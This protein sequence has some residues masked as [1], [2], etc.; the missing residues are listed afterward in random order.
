MEVSDMGQTALQ[1]SLHSSAAIASN[2]P[3]VFSDIK[4]MVGNVSYNT[5]TGE[6]TLSAVGR[7]V[8][9]W[10][11]AVQSSPST[12]GAAFALES[13]QGD[14]IEGNSPIKTDEVYGI[15]IIDVETAPVTMVLKNISTGPI[16]LSPVV[17]LQGTLVLLEDTLEG[18]PG[19]TG[20]TGPTGPAGEPGPIA[21][22]IPF[23]IGGYG[24][25]FSTHEDGYP[26][27]IKFSGF[28]KQDYGLL[29][30]VGEWQTGLITFDENM[31]YGTSFV[32]PYDGVLKS[33]YVVFSTSSLLEFD[34]GVIINPFVCIATC[35]TDELIYVIQQETMTFTDPYL[36]GEPIPQY[37]LRKAATLNLNLPLPAGT[38][39]AIVLGIMSEGTTDPQFAQLNASG[40][41]FIE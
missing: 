12:I 21:A 8:V 37:T 33:I 30:G 1:I 23:S 9:D 15:G 24:T 5:T 32:M 19:P 18:P 14:L 4:Y 17:P 27:Q 2:A 3:V 40:G 38:M 20:P 7:Y 29:I 31:Q 34:P 25:G 41:L 26:N 13:S 28:G 11:L 16:Y 35:N 22:T 10:W 36:G 6:L 39:V